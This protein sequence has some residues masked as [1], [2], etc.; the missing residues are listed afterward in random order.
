MSVKKAS[1]PNHIIEKLTGNGYKNGSIDYKMLEYRLKWE[2]YWMKTLRTI[3]SNGLNK[4]SKFLD[5]N[6]LTGK[7]F[8]HC[9]NMPNDFWMYNSK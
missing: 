1:F 8:H 2:D 5:K 9:Q 7:L 6:V 4:K 3:Y